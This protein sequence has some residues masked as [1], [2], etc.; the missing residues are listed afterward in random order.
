MKDWTGTITSTFKTIGAS[1]HTDKER[2]HNDYYATEPR[3]AELLCDLFQF[4]PYIWE[5]ACGAGH[6]A[7]VFEKRISIKILRNL[8]IRRMRVHGHLR[9]MIWRGRH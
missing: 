1:N 3:A 6:L 5:C 4:S 8:R 9:N 7:K 2:E